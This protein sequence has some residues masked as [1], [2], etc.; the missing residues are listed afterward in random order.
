[1]AKLTPL[2]KGLIAL[3]ILSVTA[4]AAW[5]LGLKGIVTDALDDAGSD[6]GHS[7][8]HDGDDGDAVGS[9]SGSGALGSHLEK[10]FRCKRMLTP[11][12]LLL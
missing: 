8:G 12:D 4:A 2:A 1:M 10:N 5:Q 7:D 6:D 11:A 3:T 9:S